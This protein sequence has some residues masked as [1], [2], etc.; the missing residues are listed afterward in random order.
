MK[1]KDIK[2][3]YRIEGPSLKKM[4]IQLLNFKKFCFI[5]LSS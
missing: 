4:T 2:L 5:N 1:L 3:M